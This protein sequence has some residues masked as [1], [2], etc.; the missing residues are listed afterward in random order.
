M[1]KSP[2]VYIRDV[3]ISNALLGIRSYNQLIGHPVFGAAWEAIVLLN[4]KAFFP[5]GDFYFYRT[6]QGAEIDFILE[7][8]GKIVAIE[9]KATLSP[10]LTK[11]NYIAKGDINPD[12]FLVISPVKEGWNDSSGNYVVNISGALG[13]INK[14][15]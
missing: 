10:S 8:S 9:C 2:K 15:I 3:G 12:L 14:I 11:G 13:K 6:S 4:L 5:K 1:V 7:Y